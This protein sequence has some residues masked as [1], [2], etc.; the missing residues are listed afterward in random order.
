MGASSSLISNTYKNGLKHLYI[1]RFKLLIQKQ[2][3]NSSSQQKAGIHMSVT[4]LG[5]NKRNNTFLHALRHS[6]MILQKTAK[7][8]E[9]LQPGSRQLP[10][11]AR[12]VLLMAGGR[13]LDDLQRMLGSDHA[14]LARQLME[15]GY[16]QWQSD[17]TVD[18][19][20]APQAVAVNTQPSK[21]PESASSSINMAGTRMYLFDMC[22]RLFAN[23][24][25]ELAQQLRTQLR[26]A[27]DLPALQEAGLTLL[28]AVQEHAGEERAQSLRERLAALLAYRNETSEKEMEESLA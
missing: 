28:H 19:A 10:Q 20:T 17:E 24:H 6:F 14:E 8:I 4:D 25:E 23:R 26:E 11:R 16:L 21:P 9:E 7:A 2:P 13:S 3:M 27:R 15:Q 18:N 22:E 12:S 1:K 5:C